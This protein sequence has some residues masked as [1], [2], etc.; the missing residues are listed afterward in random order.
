[1][2]GEKSPDRLTIFAKG[3]LNV[4]DSLHSLRTDG[5]VLWN[6]INEIVRARFPQTL[7]QLRHEVWTRSDALLEADGTVPVGLSNRQLPLNPYSASVQ[8]SRA[9]FETAANVI[10]L[11]L[12]PDLTTPL[13]RHRRD[14]YLFF[15]NNW[16]SWPSEDK[17]WLRDEFEKLD[18]LPVDG[19]MSNLARIIAQIREH[20]TVPIMIYNVSSVVPGES[21]HCHEGLADIFSTR[22]RRFNLGLVELSQQTGISVIDVDS[23]VAR[24]GADRLKLDAVHLTAEGC[25]RVAEE[26]VRVLEDFGCFSR[27]ETG[28]CS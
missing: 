5:K 8:F 26:V 24:S 3:N 9:L 19:S 20:S 10:V 28:R 27:G 11:S 18:L 15:P 12:Q 4:R 23:I 17:L 22:I 25:R 6:G 2:R 1:M 16:E 13:V 21:V 14:G 7:V